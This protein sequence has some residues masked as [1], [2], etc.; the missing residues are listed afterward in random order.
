MNGRKVLL[1]L[2]ALVLLPF[3]VFAGGKAEPQ[4]KGSYEWKFAHEEPPGV[5]Q[6]EYAK[7]FARRMADKSGG[8]IKI[9]VFPLG[10]LG[11]DLDVFEACTE[12]A[13]EFVISS[14][15]VAA[16]IVPEAQFLLLHFLFSD[17]MEVNKKIISNKNS[18]AFKGITEAYAKKNV[19]ALG[20]WSE[21]YFSW[22]CN[23]P[24]TKLADFQGVKFR[25][26]R[27]PLIVDSY[28]AYGANPTP[29]PF[30][31]VYSGLQ[32]KMIDGQ[33]NPDYY[34]YANKLFQVQDYIIIAKHALFMNATI[35]NQKFF[36]SLPKDIQKLIVDTVDKMYVWAEDWGAKFNADA[37]DKMVAERPEFK[38]VRLT[39]EQRKPFAQAAASVRQD[40]INLMEDKALARKL[41]DAI[42]KEIADA[43]KS[44]K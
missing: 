12:G 22:T 23:R 8:K 39:P 14:P 3:G 31:E 2:L 25:T 9:D 28:R 1:L 17:N 24:I 15:G 29:M 19:K 27:S 7:E 40:Y 16:T 43:E 42:V 35:V 13:I 20:Y 32:L 36:D 44:V 21:G 5:Y 30:A 41:L 33:E 4:V 18:V 26:M 6:D 10:T 37:V 11:G 34:I 38:V